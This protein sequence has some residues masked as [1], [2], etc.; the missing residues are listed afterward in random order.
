MHAPSLCAVI[1]WKEPSWNKTGVTILTL[2][3]RRTKFHLR[4]T[5][6]YLIFRASD[7]GVA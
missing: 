4:R 1:Q 3:L 2:N 7:S 6:I 5:G